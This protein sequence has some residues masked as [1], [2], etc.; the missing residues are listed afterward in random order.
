M[1]RAQPGPGPSCFSGLRREARPR[2]V[3]AGRLPS[4]AECSPPGGGCSGRDQSA[5]RPAFVARELGFAG[6]AAN[7]LDVSERS[8]L[9]AGVGLRDGP[10][11]RAP[12]RLGRGLDPLEHSGVRVS[13][14][15][16]CDLHG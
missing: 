8:R 12:L 6:V 9:R 16:R 2:P 1:Q 10:D 13:R 5:D 11:R 3:S 4:A 14:S 15:A 7:S